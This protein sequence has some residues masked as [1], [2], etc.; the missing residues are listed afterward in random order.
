M[1]DSRG[2]TA[3]TGTTSGA[4][5]TLSVRQAAFIGVG[6]AQTRIAETPRTTM[7]SA[8]SMASSGQSHLR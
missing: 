2:D 6:A 4:Q 5:R 8:A 1:V 7:L 3:S